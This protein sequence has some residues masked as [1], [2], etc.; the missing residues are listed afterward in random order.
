MNL[1]EN[2]LRVNLYGIRGTSI[3]CQGF[4][5]VTPQDIIFPPS[6]EIVDS[7]QHIANRNQ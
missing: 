5:S 2:L 1:K 7:T 3:L 6:M 4:P